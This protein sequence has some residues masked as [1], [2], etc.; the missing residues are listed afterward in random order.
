M[1]V[2]DLGQSGEGGLYTGRPRVRSM[3]R[4]G[5]FSQRV[6]RKIFSGCTRYS[7]TGCKGKAFRGASWHPAPSADQ[8][9]SSA[10]P[11]AGSGPAVKVEN[12]E[13]SEKALQHE[14]KLPEVSAERVFYDKSLAEGEQAK[15][16][17]MLAVL[18]KKILHDNNL[19]PKKDF[20]AVSAF[21]LG[22]FMYQEARELQQGLMDLAVK[23]KLKAKEAKS[24]ECEGAAD[25]AGYE[26]AGGAMGC[27]STEAKQP[28]PSRTANLTQPRK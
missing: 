20:E 27:A 14:E 8:G 15:Q 2:C 12:A 3:C 13:V 9:Q 5:H 24:S 16:E 1:D 17:E 23:K 18:L 4:P 10:S 25:A 22:D 11:G 7:Q 21:V 28:W 6:G 26:I 19:V